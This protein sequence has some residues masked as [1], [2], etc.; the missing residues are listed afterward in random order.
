MNQKTLIDTR[1]VVRAA[2]W[3]HIL[4]VKTGSDRTDSIPCY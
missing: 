3:T 4:H 1:L 2:E